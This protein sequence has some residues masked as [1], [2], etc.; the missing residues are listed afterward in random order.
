MS[1]VSSTRRVARTPASWAARIH[2]TSTSCCYRGYGVDDKIDQF[3]ADLDIKGDDPKQGLVDLQVGGYFSRDQKDTALYSNDGLAGCTDLRLQH[4][5]ANEHSDRRIQRRQQ[6][7]VGSEWRE[8]PADPV[9][10]LRRTGIVQ[11]D[12]PTATG[13]CNPAFTFAPPLRND[14]VVTERVFGG[15]LEAVFAG[16]LL[17]RPITS[18]VGVRVEDTQSTVNGLST[19]FIA[20]AQAAQRRRHNM[21]LIP[22]ATPRYRPRTAIRTFCPTCRSSG[23]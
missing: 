13:H 4:P 5:R 17:D 22:A 9:A 11:R 7:P 19:P 1:P 2:C 18:V 16:S 8:S 3:R 12:H 23:T 15:Y 10:H 6:L 21:A 20:A 14:S